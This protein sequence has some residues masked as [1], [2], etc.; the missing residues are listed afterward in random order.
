MLTY[1]K[2]KSYYDGS[3][4]TKEQVH[5]AVKYNKITSEQYELITKEP[6]VA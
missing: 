3:Y 5:T 1:D 2:I 6:Y 4:W